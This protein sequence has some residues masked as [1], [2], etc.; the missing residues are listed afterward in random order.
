MAERSFLGSGATFYLDAT[1]LQQRLNEVR[2]QVTEQKFK[3]VTF[4]TFK[5]VARKSQTL[6]AKEVV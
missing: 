6:V 4:R 1:D 5:E 2:S 3:Q